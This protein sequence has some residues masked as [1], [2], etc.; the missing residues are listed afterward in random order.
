MVLDPLIL[1]KARHWGAVGEE[2]ADSISEYADG[3]QRPL[4]AASTWGGGVGLKIQYPPPD[5]QWQYTKTFALSWVLARLN[6][7]ALDPICE[8][9]LYLAFAL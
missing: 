4:M 2:F 1:E 6:I 7:S 5:A 3:R 8:S 9:V